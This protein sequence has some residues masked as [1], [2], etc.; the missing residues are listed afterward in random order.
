MEGLQAEKESAEKQAAEASAA[1][2]A[3]TA[4][5][6]EETVAKLQAEVS[7]L[8]EEAAAKDAASTKADAAVTQTEGVSEQPY[9]DKVTTNLL[10]ASQKEVERLSEVVAKLEQE[11]VC[12]LM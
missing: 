11:K 10:K 9:G 2:A 6:H 4:Q 7:K 1:E 8:T 12:A 3:A 5:R